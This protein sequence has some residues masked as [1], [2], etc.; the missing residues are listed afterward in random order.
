M[1]VLGV[2]TDAQESLLQAVAATWPG[3]PHQI[4]QFHALRALREAGRVLYERD[5][6]IKVQMRTLLQARIRTVRHQL[7]RKLAAPSSEGP[8]RP[9]TAHYARLLAEDAAGLKVCPLLRRE[10]RRLTTLAARGRPPPIGHRRGSQLIGALDQLADPA[11]RAAGAKCD[12]RR[13]LPRLT[14]YMICHHVG[15]TAPLAVR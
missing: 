15:S 6:A 2:V 7:D 4:G 12:R 13:R 9:D 8:D 5:R 10:R 14:S 1:P 11:S 3:V